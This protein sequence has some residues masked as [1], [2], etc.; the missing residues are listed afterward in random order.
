MTP[1]RVLSLIPMFYGDKDLLV[2]TETFSVPILTPAA[3]LGRL[4]ED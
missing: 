4:P 1:S 3:F 2:L